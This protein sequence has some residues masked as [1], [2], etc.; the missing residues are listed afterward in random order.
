MTPTSTLLHK[1]NGPIFGILQEPQ[2]AKNSGVTAFA[3]FEE[4]TSKDDGEQ[5]NA[6]LKARLEDAG[7][8][9]GFLES[10]FEAMAWY[11]CNVGPLIRPT[12][13]AE[14]N[15]T[16]PYLQSGDPARWLEAVGVPKD[17]AVW[18][19]VV[20]YRPKVA[21]YRPTQLDA[22]WY[23]HHFPSPPRAN[24][25][26]GGFAM[27]LRSIDAAAT[28]GLVSEYIHRQV[29]FTL[30]DWNRAGGLVGF[31][32]KPNRGESL[33]Q[34]RDQHLGILKREYGDDPDWL[35]AAQ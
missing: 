13:A 30:P 21:V 31:V 24:L 17:Y 23:A 27:Y 26:D 2:E 3:R 32:E 34:L 8:P 10:V 19:A 18:I 6:F 29:D 15:S 14:W 4:A 28:T 25:S 5:V 9:A 20:R 7:G 16:A 1:A 35:M 12:W 11:R 33:A 22:G